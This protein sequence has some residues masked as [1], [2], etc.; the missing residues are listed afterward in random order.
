[1]E[2]RRS[3]KSSFRKEKESLGLFLCLL[4]FF[5]F[6]QLKT[7]YGGDSGDFLSTAAVWS[8]PHPPGY[9]LYAFLAAILHH[10]FSWGTPA[11]RIAFLSS[12]PAAL[13]I[14][15]FY[16]LLRLFFSSFVSLITGLFLAFL[17]PFWLYSEAVEVFSLNNFFIVSLTYLIFKFL[18]TNKKKYIYWFFIVLGLSFAHHHIIVFLFPALI[19]VGKKVWPK[20]KNWQAALLVLP[21]LLF[22]LYLPITA[23]NNPPINWG[24]PANFK[25]FLNVFFRRGY[26]TFLAN[27]GIDNTLWGRFFSTLAFGRFW[28]ADFSWLGIFLSLIGLASYFFVKDKTAKRFWRYSFISFSSFIFF[29]F[30]ASF[31]LNSD[32][33]VATYERFLIAPY[34]FLT[35][36]LAFGLNFILKTL[37]KIFKEKAKRKLILPLAYFAFFVAL[38][39]N[40]FANSFPKISILK[41]DFTAE[42]FAQDILNTVP[43]RS[44]VFLSSDTT[45]FNAA[46]IYYSLGYRKKEV[47]LVNWFSLGSDYYQQ[48]LKKEFPDLIL[49]KAGRGSFEKF[50][51]KNWQETPIYIIPDKKMEGFKLVP[52]GLLFRYYKEDQL[53]TPES[54]IEENKKIWVNYQDPNKGSLSIFKNLFLA[55]IPNYYRESSKRLGEYFLENKQYLQ[56]EEYLLKSL[57]YDKKE[58]ETHLLLGRVY[59]ETERCQSA[60]EEFLKVKELLPDNPFPDA[61]LRQLYLKCFE[62]RDKA[63]DFLDS[64]F[65][66]EQEEQLKLE[67]I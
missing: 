26:G 40:T 2:K 7:V 12:V 8:I 59:L 54:V 13:T 15:F 44:V 65:E 9:P 21:G 29:L 46:Y 11:W 37:K 14:F 3:F 35:I 43:K 22:Y 67:D 5:V 61:Y 63:K 19:Y 36:F 1:M 34:I 62:D 60:E 10:F 45:W 27:P 50:I 64:C 25:N 17:Y 16:R 51:E 31:R 30:Y 48:Y 4:I 20:K 58:A 49:E 41:N 23:R 42:K 66:K 53:P 52:F 57:S 39:L 56:G 38:P 24:N 55:D 6:F 47:K 32:F 28:L 18:K 33:S